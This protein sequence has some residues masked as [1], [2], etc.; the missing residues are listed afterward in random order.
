[1]STYD[2]TISGLDPFL[3]SHKGKKFALDFPG[4]GDQGNKLPKL[5]AKERRRRMKKCEKVLLISICDIIYGRAPEF[6][7]P[8]K[9]IIQY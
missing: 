4:D 6:E 2:V 3:L 5:L 8:R 7:D 1:M 9:R